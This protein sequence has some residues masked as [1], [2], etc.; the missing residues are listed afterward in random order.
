MVIC[1]NVEGVQSEKGCNICSKDTDVLVYYM[2][3]S[4]LHVSAD[5]CVYF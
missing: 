4:T 2:Q 5:I 3:F 1:R